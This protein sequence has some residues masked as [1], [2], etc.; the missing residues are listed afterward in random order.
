MKYHRI[1]L[2]LFALLIIFVISITSLAQEKDKAVKDKVDK[3]EEMQR[4][5]M[6]QLGIKS[7]VNEIAPN[8]VLKDLEGK[9]ISLAQLKDK[10][11]LIDFWATWC[12]PCRKALPSI[13]KL[14]KE[15]ESKGLV[16]LAISTEEPEVVKQFLIKNKLT[17]K[18]LIDKGMETAKKFSVKGLPTVFIIGRD[19]KVVS[20]MTGGSEEGD[21]KEEIFLRNELK[22]AGI[23]S[24]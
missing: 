5:I 22:K 10:V 23:D 20:H 2:S 19:G 6:I 8:F 17:I 18:S 16:T 4:Q 14:S 9:E 11:V 1:S 7:M 12:G 13:E 21:N 15:F 3:Q 24:N